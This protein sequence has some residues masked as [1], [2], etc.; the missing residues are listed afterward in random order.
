M[1]VP[2]IAKPWNWLSTWGKSRKPIKQESEETFKIK[3]NRS[4]DWLR[5]PLD[6]FCV[7]VVRHHHRWDTWIQLKFAEEGKPP[8]VMWSRC[9]FMNLEYWNNITDMLPHTFITAGV[10]AALILSVDQ[11]LLTH[12]HLCDMMGTRVFSSVWYATAQKIPD[13]WRQRRYLPSTEKSALAL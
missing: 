6:I 12:V 4:A 3:M 11:Q 2:E 9:A 1:R 5:Q 10:S 7:K 13:R 8:C